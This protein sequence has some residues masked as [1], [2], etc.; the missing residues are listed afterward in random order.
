MGEFA[1]Q[2]N[3][4]AHIVA[5]AAAEQGHPTHYNSANPIRL[6]VIQV[7][8]SPGLGRI[9]QPRVIAEVI[10][11]I[12]LGPTVMGRLPNF[13]ETIFP[14]E[15]MPLLTLTANIGLIL[16][17]FLVGLEIDTRLLK[18]NAKASLT[19]SV[20]G[21]II[22]LGLGAAL[23]VGVYRQFIDPSVTLW[24]LP[25]VHRSRRRYHCLPRSL[26]DPHRAQAPRYS[27]RRCGLDGALCSA[28]VGC[29]HHLFALP[30]SMG[31]R[32]TYSVMM[33]VTVLVVFISAFFTDIIGV[34]AI[35][36]GFLAGLIVP[37]D[38][39][40][41]IALVEKIEDLIR[42]SSFLLYYFTLSG[43]KTNLGLLDDGITWG[44]TI[45]I[46]VVAFVAKF[47]PCAGAAMV[48]GFQL[49]R[50]CLVELIVLNIGRQAGILDPRTFSMFVVHALVLTFHRN[51]SGLT[52][53][54]AKKP[55]TEGSGD[56]SHVDSEFRTKFSLVLEKVD[57][58]APAMT[59]TQ[60]LQP[61]NSSSTLA[62][63]PSALDKAAEAYGSEDDHHD[64]SRIQVDALRLME[65][66]NR[67][68]DVIRSQEADALIYNDPV[69]SAFRTFGT[70]LSVHGAKSQMVIIPW[71][72]G[73]T[74]LL[75]D[76]DSAG[77]V[78]AHNPFDGVFRR[79]STTDQDI[80]IRSVFL[81]CPRDVALFVDRG[82]PTTST[83]NEQRLFLPIFG[84]PDDRL[85]LSFLVQLCVR[86][87]VSATVSGSTVEAP[88][89]PGVPGASNPNALTVA[90]ADTVYGALT[91]TAR[92]ASD[93]EDNLIWER[94]TGTS[95]THS[96]AI[97]SALTK[98]TFSTMSTENPLH[99]VVEL[100]NAEATQTMARRDG[101]TVI[102][103]AGRS[104][105]LA[106]ESLGSELRKIISETNSLLG[107]VGAAL[108]ATNAN[109]SLLIMQAA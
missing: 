44:Y 48:F 29:V 85:A 31:L 34:H 41:A 77:G 8:P 40:F 51:T 97:S 105:R 10:G 2:L 66:G 82:A 55:D 53:S 96:G 11:G 3:E 67:T 68:S 102:V 16:F 54:P 19:V 27:S 56:E 59:L 81:Q 91:T 47:A 12:L 109:A 100:V 52:P 103:I 36:G 108:V 37:H 94:Y 35:F 93:T 74:S 76:Q 60:L 9:R 30:Y 14:D 57:Q 75:D 84:G 88:T 90:A 32:N 89:S 70:S 83:S 46:C 86:T 58:L 39:G 106:V 33:T 26:S 24:L 17:L 99:K 80:F 98:I 45:L 4:A 5:R 71:A 107:D 43:L 22:P 13:K 65:L 79:T 18:R 95:S 7:D 104:R 92:L 20:A 78:H 63:T 6:W 28:R 1:R 61:N 42:S 64:A 25:L 21:L 15:S 38:N 73:T 23:G 101:K 49:A 87:G 50:V 62:T 69:V 72:R